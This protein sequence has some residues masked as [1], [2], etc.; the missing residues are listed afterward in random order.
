VIDDFVYDHTY[1][2]FGLATII[3]MLANALAP[4]QPI[5]LIGSLPTLRLEQVKIAQQL[6]PV[7]VA[8]KY[9]F[10]E[11]PGEIRRNLFAVL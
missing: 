6:V 8:I 3:F 2:F 1:G 4:R 10:S 9:C 5:I 7:T 11:P